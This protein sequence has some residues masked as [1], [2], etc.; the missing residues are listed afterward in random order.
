LLSYPFVI[1]LVQVPTHS[2]KRSP[3]QS[4][5]S[6]KVQKTSLQEVTSSRHFVMHALFVPLQRASKVG[7]LSVG[8]S[9]A[10]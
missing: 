3:A 5:A 10:S 9:A 1:A 7:P 8:Q 4:Q 6:Q 2:E